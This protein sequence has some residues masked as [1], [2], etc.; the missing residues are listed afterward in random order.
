[1]RL[2][3]TVIGAVALLALSGCG[4]LPTNTS[5][6]TANS[7]TADDLGYVY[8]AD[9]SDAVVTVNVVEDCDQQTVYQPD[10]CL[11]GQR[12]WHNGLSGML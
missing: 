4:S 5:W 9:T 2:L 7:R 6:V 1:M 8:E 12:Q 10:G 11:G 3:L